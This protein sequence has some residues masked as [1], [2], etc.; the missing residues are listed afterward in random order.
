MST[1]HLLHVPNVQPPLPIDWQVRPTHPVHD[2]VPY[3]LAK[4]WDQRPDGAGL[5]RERAEERRAAFAAASHRKMHIHAHSGAVVADRADLVGT[6][7]AGLRAK[8]KRTPAVKGWLRGLEEPVRDFMVARGLFRETTQSHDGEDADGSSDGMDSEDEEIVFVGRNG[9]TRDGGG[10]RKA[11]EERNWRLAQVR[12]RPGETGMV[13]D[14]TAGDE[15]SSAFRY[16][17]ALFSR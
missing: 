17:V 11:A 6:V 5:L 13:L 9:R 15:E 14:T 12:D 7:P 16:V 2:T 4:L 10:L 3:Q 8:C 1:D